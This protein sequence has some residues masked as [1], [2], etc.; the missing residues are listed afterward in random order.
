MDR[1]ANT[2]VGSATTEV[3]THRSIDFR[4]ARVRCMLQQGGGRHD[5]A[6]LAVAALRH[7]DRLPGHLYR[8]QAIRGKPLNGCDRL[9]TDAAHRR[10]AGADGV[11]SNDHSASPA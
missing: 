4:I 9:T 10:H 3:P 1:L 6:C 8:M 5:L 11:A 7:V 2:R